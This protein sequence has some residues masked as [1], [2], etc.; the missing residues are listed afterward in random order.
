MVVVGM[1]GGG[2]V[3]FCKSRNLDGLGSER[4]FFILSMNQGGFVARPGP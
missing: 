4:T 1:E 2:G 3:E